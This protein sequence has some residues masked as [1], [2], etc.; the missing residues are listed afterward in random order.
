MSPKNNSTTAVGR[1]EVNGKIAPKWI[2]ME[3]LVDEIELGRQQ[4]RQIGWLLALENSAD[5]DADLAKRTR[6]KL[7][8]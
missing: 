3:F 2:V 1:N 5:I 8:P 4:H 6:R 7:L